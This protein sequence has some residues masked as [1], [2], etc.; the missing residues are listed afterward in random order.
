VSSRTTVRSALSLLT[1][2]ALAASTVLVG[3]AAVAAPDGPGGLGTV[4][5]EPGRY[6]VTLVDPAVATY[7]GG[8]PGLSATRPDEGDQLNARR[9]PARDYSEY[10]QE[11]QQDVAA[12]AGVDRRLAQCIA[13]CLRHC[14]AFECGEKRGRSTLYAF[15][16]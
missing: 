1:A 7:D 13:Y 16:A 12:A 6:I 4:S 10:L 14:G 11:R 2:A 15:A 8:V 3:T 9:A 5:F